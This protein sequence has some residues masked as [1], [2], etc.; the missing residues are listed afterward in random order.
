MHRSLPSL[1][2]YLLPSLLFALLL[3]VALPAAAAPLDLAAYKGRVVYVDFWASW[4]GPC[5]QSFPWMKAMHERHAADG[6]VIVAVNVDAEKAQADAFLREFAPAFPVVF[7]PKGELAREFK[8]QS[9]PSSYLIGRDGRARYLHRGF[10]DAKREQY[11]QE[12][13]ELLAEKT[14]AP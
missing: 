7:D 4:C 11:E 10:H 9:M 12:I 6:L 1:L 3:P 2:R 13:R 14:P 8:V 5:R